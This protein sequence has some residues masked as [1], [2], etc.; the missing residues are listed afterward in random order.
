MTESQ[1]PPKVVIKPLKHQRFTDEDLRPLREGLEE[2]GLETEIVR[3]DPT[4][5]RPGTFGVNWYEVIHVYLPHLETVASAFAGG[6]AADLTKAAA[7]DGIKALA[8]RIQPIFIRWAKIRASTG[9]RNP[10]QPKQVQIYGPDGK[11]VMTV[12]VNDPEDEPRVL[13][14]D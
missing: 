12:T 7:K 11:V 2:L 6:V 5:Q 13:D 8:K 9:G 10:K 3:E 4:P 1:A 14:H